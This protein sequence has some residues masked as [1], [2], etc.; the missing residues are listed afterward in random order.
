[1]RCGKVLKGEMRLIAYILAT[2]VACSPAAAQSWMEYNYPDFAFTVSF[3]AEPR[4]ETTIYQAA[5]GRPVPARVYSATLD[6]GVFKM[7]VADLTAAALE[8]S[9]VI[10]HAIKT[11]SRGG[12]IKLD[13]P[14]RI[15]RVFGRQLS[16][17]A[18]DGSRS[19]V[20][21]FYHKQRLYQIEGKALA[22]GNSTADA[23]RFQQS[24]VFTD[25]D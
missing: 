4:I 22:A 19:S 9:A 13:I 11:L 5:D 10:D 17:Q 16:I 18:P 15:S 20:A 25:S 8:E 3:P 14:H 1:M 2:F 12:E 6:K 21:V 23:I 7:T 24:L